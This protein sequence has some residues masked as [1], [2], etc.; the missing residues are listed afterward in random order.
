MALRHPSGRFACLGLVTIVILG[1]ASLALAQSNE[2]LGTRAQGMAG[3]FVGVADDA[4]AVYWNPAG[5]ARGAY[6]SLVI[7]GNNADSA[8]ATQ[9]NAIRTSGWLVALTTPALGISY[10]RLNTS[11]AT[12]SLTAPGTF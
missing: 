7:D 2:R 10:Y 11:A 4:S 5:L 8:P 3:A 6:F 1:S 9:S 12:P